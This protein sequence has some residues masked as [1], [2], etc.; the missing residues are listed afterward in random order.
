YILFRLHTFVEVSIFFLFAQQL[1]RLAGLGRNPWLVSKY[2]QAFFNEEW[3]VEFQEVLN[4]ERNNHP[5]RKRGESSHENQQRGKFGNPGIGV[6]A[7]ANN[8]NDGSVPKGTNFATVNEVISRLSVCSK[9]KSDQMQQHDQDCHGPQ[10]ES[11]FFCRR[12]P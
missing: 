3:I 11:N 2:L 12:I 4:D 1:H 6:E 8:K 7:T 9:R 5:H 10:R